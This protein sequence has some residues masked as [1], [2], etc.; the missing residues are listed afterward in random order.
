[1]CLNIGETNRIVCFKQILNTFQYK[2]LKT[3][4]KIKYPQK[5]SYEEMEKI[6]KLKSMSSE[7]R[8]RRW[9]WLGHVLRKNRAD[10]SYIA[11]GWTPEGS[12]ARGRPSTT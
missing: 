3:N 10:N 1:M 5:I 6:T 4:L 2:C 11:L 8:R 12:R 9:N 7:I